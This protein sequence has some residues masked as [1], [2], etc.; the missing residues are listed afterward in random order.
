[1]VKCYFN[2]A[3]N[4]PIELSPYSTVLLP[5]TPTKEDLPVN[6][7]TYIQHQ[8]HLWR[9]EPEKNIT[10]NNHFK[11]FINKKLANEKA[12]ESDSEE[13]FLEKIRMLEMENQCLKNEIKNQQAVIEMLITNDKC[14]NEW[15][16]V[17]TKFKNSTNVASPS[18][19]SW[20]NPSPVN[21]QNQFDN[22][23]VTEANQT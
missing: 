4:T 16:T 1:M 13:I 14:T 8:I 23:I 17:K 6:E 9:Q 5:K 2:I 19:V 3:T 7:K 12:I 11:N 22:H 20:K 18:S 21:L 15:E 10:A